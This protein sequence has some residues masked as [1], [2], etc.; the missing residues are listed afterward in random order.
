MLA[1][2][3]TVSEYV[4]RAFSPLGSAARTVFDRYDYV[5]ERWF[6]V[7][8]MIERV[9]W[10]ISMSLAVILVTII[11]GQV[12][13]RYIFEWIP[14]WGGELGRALGIW[15]SLLLLPALVW[16]DKHLQVEFMFERLPLRMRRRIRS[17]QLA[18][19][20]I[21]GAAYTYYGWDYATTAGF[22]SVSTSLDKLFVNFPLVG[23]GFELDM[24]WV[25]VILPASGVLFV[26]AAVSK[27]I[28]IN[29]NP[30]QLQED[31]SERYGA[32]EIGE[33]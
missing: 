16:S 26:V 20:S 21:F 9:L 15:A 5:F 19:L 25:Y 17:V 32:V 28:Q 13:T 11:A 4:D 1:I 29:Y 33:D 7:M 14:P 30:D 27:L 8:D 12:V 23:S 31:Y 22:R 3:A 18:M 10:A 6:E 2:S 24:F